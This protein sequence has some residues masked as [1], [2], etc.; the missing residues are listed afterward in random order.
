MAGETPQQYGDDLIRK[1]WWAVAALIVVAEL[2]GLAVGLSRTLSFR[3]PVT[4][5]V[6]ALAASIYAFQRTPVARRPQ[7]LRSIAIAL[8]LGGLVAM[9]YAATIVR[10]GGNV[11]NRPL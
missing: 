6:I 11:L 3:L 4:L 2:I 8:M 9:F 5:G 1:G 10:L 7:K